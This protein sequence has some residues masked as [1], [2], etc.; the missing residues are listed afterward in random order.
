M[1]VEMPVLILG[2]TVSDCIRTH[3]SPGS[4]AGYPLFVRLSNRQGWIAIRQLSRPM[5]L[6]LVKA[7]RVRQGD[8]FSIFSG[9][10]N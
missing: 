1:S 7:P 6:K 5:L 10:V 2:G 8:I 4:F 3:P 9:L